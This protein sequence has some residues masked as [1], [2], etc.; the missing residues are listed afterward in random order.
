MFGVVASNA[1]NLSF[2]VVMRRV[3]DKISWLLLAC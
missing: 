1:V 2:M 3:W